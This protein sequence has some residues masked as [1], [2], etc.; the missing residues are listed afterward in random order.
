MK[1]DSDKWDIGLERIDLE[2]FKQAIIKAVKEINNFETKLGK[3]IKLH[4][5][6]IQKWSSGIVSP[7]LKKKHEVLNWITKNSNKSI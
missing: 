4:P 7:S 1:N 6:S 5:E 3:V 2:E